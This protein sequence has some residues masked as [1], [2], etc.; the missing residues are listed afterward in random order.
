MPARVATP[1]LLAPALLA[2]V[3]VA[4][5]LGEPD[6]ELPRSRPEIV[7]VSPPITEIKTVTPTSANAFA[8]IRFDVD[9]YSDDAGDALVTLLIQDYGV[10]TDPDDPRS[11]PWLFVEPDSLDPAPSRDVPKRVSRVFTP[12]LVDIATHAC[13]T[14]SILATHE[15]FGKG[16]FDRCPKDGK[17]SAIVTWYVT[18]CNDLA[19]CDF[20]DCNARMPPGGYRY[21]PDDPAAFPGGLPP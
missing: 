16:P 13:T 15:Q 3:L 4:C 12:R 7:V 2:C 6:H 20:A 11:E 18:Y 9:I 8:P 10:P 21:C 5:V 1:A 17:D 19:D 14:I